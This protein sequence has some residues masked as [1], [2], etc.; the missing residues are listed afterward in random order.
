MLPK[1]KLGIEKIDDEKFDFVPCVQFLHDF[2]NFARKLLLVLS[3]SYSGKTSGVL[4]GGALRENRRYVLAHSAPFKPD[5][6]TLLVDYDYH[7]FVQY[8]YLLSLAT[9]RCQIWLKLY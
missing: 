2:Q 6:Q 7:R 9:Q 5:P 4:R 8:N 1:K 3:V